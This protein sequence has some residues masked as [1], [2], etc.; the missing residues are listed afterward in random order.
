ME[1]RITTLAPARNPAYLPSA[2]AVLEVQALKENQS[3]PIEDTM[4]QPTRK[5]GNS[6]LLLLPNELLQ[7]IYLHCLEPNLAL[8]SGV[9]G[10][11]LSSKTLLEAT[12]LQAFWSPNP[13]HFINADVQPVVRLPRYRLLSQSANLK[14]QNPEEQER[15]QWL[16]L[17]QR[18]ST[19]TRL[20][21]CFSQLLSAVCCDMFQNL[22]F[23][24]RSEHQFALDDLIENP[25]RQRITFAATS[26]DGSEIFLDYSW[27][28]ARSLRLTYTGPDPYFD[29]LSIQNLAIEPTA[30]MTLPDSCLRS[31]PWTESKI[32]KL[33]ILC[34]G[35]NRKKARYSST[36]FHAGMKNAVLERNLT[37]LL[38]LAWAADRIYQMRNPFP[39]DAPFELPPDIFRLAISISSK[40]GES[41]DATAI[42]IFKI[43]LRS[44]AESMPKSDDGIVAWATHLLSRPSSQAFGRWLIDF[45]SRPEEKEHM[46]DMDNGVRYGFREEWE[47]VR[48][49]FFE[50]GRISYK[51]SNH[52]I[53]K[54][55][56]RAEGGEPSSFEEEIASTVFRI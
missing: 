48:R 2:Y 34:Y 23:S 7:L 45:S 39:H 56:V 40:D 19:F 52:E 26:L 53:M 14:E 38:V 1:L 36:A 41:A 44:H 4:S 51:R 37:A 47:T 31:T 21:K 8:A 54:S 32:Q 50:G 25:P 10:A 12:L 18:W 20:R 46:I 33:R 17:T 29:S 30:V 13:L 15:M 3:F 27:P 24:L 42:S 22:N 35:V 49:P 55:F 43:L 6:F 5:A 28:F 9:L 16:V 11:A